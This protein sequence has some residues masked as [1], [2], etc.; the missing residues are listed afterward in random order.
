VSQVVSIELS[1][2]DAQAVRAWKR[3]ADSI[4]HFLTTADKIGSTNRRNTDTMGTF[5]KQQGAGLAQAAIGF[6]GVGSAVAAVATAAALL[7]A[8]YDNLLERQRAAVTT[9]LPFEQQLAGAVRNASGF[10]NAASVR[11]N[12]MQ[13]SSEA[14]VTPS[15]AANLMGQTFTMTGVTNEAEANL[16]L[17]AAR[18]SA[19]YAPD[20][21]DDELAMMGG[22]SGSLSKRFGVSPEAA[23]GFAQNVATSSNVAQLA[24]V[25]KNIIPAAA[26]LT[27]LGFSM[28]DAGAFLATMTNTTGDDQGA[29]SASTAISMAKSLR[30]RF[31]QRAE[32]QTDGRF[33]LMK[34][35][36]YIQ[37]DPARLRSFI[38]GGEFFGETFGKAAIGEG[39][40][41]TSVEGFLTPGSAFSQQFEGA[42]GTVGDF[43]QGEKTY[44]R[45]QAEVQSVTPLSQLQRGFTAAN[46]SIQVDDQSAIGRLALDEVS[47]IQQSIGS[48]SLKQR[49]TGLKTELESGFGTDPV[50]ALQTVRETLVAETRDLKDGSKQLRATGGG[51]GGVVYSA[52]QVPATPSQLADAEKLERLIAVLNQVANQM[53]N[54]DGGV[55]VVDVEVQVA[56]RKVNADVRRPPTS[57][58]PSTALSSTPTSGP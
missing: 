33:D 2:E 19:L 50:S 26:N 18:A 37:Q 34:A 40:G 43:G 6:V 30:E 11:Q 7:R 1:V 38:D 36:D 24:P 10:M 46:E 15:A 49:L 27:D 57:Q 54:P 35:R 9:Q 17:R 56:Q 58:R 13:L 20:L 4:E 51:L 52:Q 44:R 28:Q 55:R 29:T 8:E 25:V 12:V 42:R 39:K 21:P 31:G 48:S 14:M 32:F 3:S 47:K 41:L 22:V 53:Q 16:A 23:I 45:I 5:F